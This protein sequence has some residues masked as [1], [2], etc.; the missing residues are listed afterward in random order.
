MEQH[1]HHQHALRTQYVKSS[2]RTPT[3]VMDMLNV[4]F[5][6]SFSYLAQPPAYASESHPPWQFPPLPPP[7]AYTLVSPSR[8]VPGTYSRAL[9]RHRS[10]RWLH[11]RPTC[12][13]AWIFGSLHCY[14]RP[15]TLLAF[16]ILCHH[17]PWHLWMYLRHSFLPS[18]SAFRTSLRLLSFSFLFMYGGCPPA[19]ITQN[20]L[21]T[22]KT[23]FMASRSPKQRKLYTTIV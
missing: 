20:G 13:H 17:F 16:W 18:A 15:A 7:S 12:A 23:A 9:P 3:H 10:R 21:T 8:H 1:P 11:S 2:T 4:T 6:P 5:T 19:S 22:G 14:S